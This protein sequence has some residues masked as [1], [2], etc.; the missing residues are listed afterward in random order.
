MH[1]EESF[2]CND[3]FKTKYRGGKKKYV[4]TVICLEDD[5]EKCFKVGVD[6]S[7]PLTILYSFYFIATI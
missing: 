2:D 1:D 7:H 6:D 5:H 3:I 4:H